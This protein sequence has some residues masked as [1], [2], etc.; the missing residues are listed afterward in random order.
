MGNLDQFHI[1]KRTPTH[2]RKE[3]EEKRRPNTNESKLNV[4][5]NIH[6]IQQNITYFVFGASF[7]NEMKL[8]D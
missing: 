1:H 5:V 6:T 2:T 4:N 3:E 8:I 7:T